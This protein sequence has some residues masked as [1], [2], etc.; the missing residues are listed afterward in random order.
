MYS[1]CTRQCERCARVLTGSKRTANCTSWPR[2]GKRRTARRR[3]TGDAERRTAAVRTVRTQ[4][5]KRHT[6][7]RTAKWHTAKRRMAKQRTAKRRT[8]KPR[9]GRP[10]TATHTDRACSGL[11]GLRGRLTVR[12][13]CAVA[14][15]RWPLGRTQSTRRRRAERTMISVEKT[16]WTVL[17]W[18][19]RQC[20]FSVRFY[21]SPFNAARFDLFLNYYSG[22]PSFLGRCAK[23]TQTFYT[24]VWKTI[25]IFN[26]GK[27]K[28]VINFFQEHIYVLLQKYNKNDRLANKNKCWLLTFKILLIFNQ[29]TKK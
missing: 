6:K 15:R 20:E 7:W 5:G 27:I 11:P 28:V 1:W 2:T 24:R 9:T 29:K 16:E 18:Q 26:S 19:I 17:L 4:T 8:G 14:V 21:R 22:K 3:R 13:A 10:H 12:T 25:Y 23:R